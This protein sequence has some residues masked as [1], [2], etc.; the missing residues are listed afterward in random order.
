MEFDDFVEQGRRLVAERDRNAWALGDL[1]S[2]FEI[3]VGRPV[4]GEDLPTLR[5]L[6]DAWEVSPQR[7]SEWR[8]CAIY[9]PEKARQAVDLSWEYFNLAR[10]AAPYDLEEAMDLLERAADL[11]LTVSLFRQYIKGTYWAGAVQRI[12]L[13]AELRLKIPDSQALVWVEMRKYEEGS[14][15]PGGPTAGAGP[16]RSGRRVNPGNE[17]TGD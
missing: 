8:N 16:G 1:A 12:L 6:A 9:Y 7:V 10:R 14:D 3:T 4:L 11:H 13:P 17:S 15:A 5:D 2:E